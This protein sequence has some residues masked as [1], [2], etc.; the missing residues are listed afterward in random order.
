MVSAVLSAL[1]VGY[2]LLM[3]STG[4]SLCLTCEKNGRGVFAPKSEEASGAAAALRET[5]Q[6]IALDG[7]SN[8]PSVRSSMH[9]SSRQSA[10]PDSPLNL[11]VGASSPT[12]MDPQ[13]SD[14]VDNSV[15]V[16]SDAEG[17]ETQH[18]ALQTRA[19]MKVVNRRPD[20]MLLR[21]NPS[22][23]TEEE[24]EHLRRVKGKGKA[25]ITPVKRIL[26]PLVFREEST[27][28]SRN[29]IAWQ[30]PEDLVDASPSRDRDRLRR[31]A[32]INAEEVMATMIHDPW[33]R[34]RRLG[35]RMSMLNQSER[36]DN[37]SRAASSFVGEEDALEDWSAARCTTCLVSCDTLIQIGEFSVPLCARYV[38]SP[39][40]H[41]EAPS[42]R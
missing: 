28:P 5:F 13:G 42:L 20:S 22:E 33:Q 34:G 35:K 30:P 9:R 39:L 3:M 17:G 21:L 4:N 25:S 23:L 18:S 8:P 41:L 16:T 32:Q 6:D 1:T 14:S 26:A 12:P 38:V 40:D 36:E 27:T 2:S 19:V 7:A 29:I 11:K 15:D 37:E 10:R 24:K 31:A